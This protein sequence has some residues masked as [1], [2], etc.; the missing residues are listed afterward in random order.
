MNRPKVSVIVPTHNSE[1]YISEALDSLLAQTFKCFEVICVDSSSDST[2]RIL[3]TYSSEYDCFKIIYDQ[4]GSYGHKLNKGISEACGD[5]LA[6]LESDDLFTEHMLEIL[7]SKALENDVDFVKSSYS[8]F[9]SL[10]QEKVFV[11]Q[12][13]YYGY[14]YLNQVIDPHELPNCRQY[15]SN[16]IWTGLYKAKFIEENDIRF[17]ESPGASY[18][19]TGF[20]V[21]CAAYARKIMLIGDNLYLYRRDNEGSSV[22]SQEKYKCVYDE[23]KWLNGELEKRNLMSGDIITYFNLTKIN[24]YRWNVAR[25]NS[26]YREA[27]LD[28]VKSDVDEHFF[29][30]VKEDA[31]LKEKSAEH[32]NLTKELLKKKRSI[33][34]FGAGIKGES[35]VKLASLLGEKDNVVLCDNDSRKWGTK[36]DGVS[37]KSPEFI[38]KKSECNVVLAIDEKNQREVYKQLL[39]MGIEEDKILVVPFFPDQDNL[40]FNLI[41]ALG[42]CSHVS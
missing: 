9:F 31:M 14:K 1:K 22:K 21:L 32:F 42:Q 28:L 37:I 13:I 30:I 33:V 11:R 40:V 17:N 18:Q 41:R 35:V 10:N 12:H 24:A 36:L 20:S 26:D 6:I 27:F 19:D 15:T 8:N 3:E 2:P 39:A 16:N 38:S 29:K 25:L 5:Y 34:I 7:Y 4:N 23:I